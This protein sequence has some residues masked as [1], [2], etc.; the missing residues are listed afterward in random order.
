MWVRCFII[1][2]NARQT[3]KLQRTKLWIAQAVATKMYRFAPELSTLRGTG[4]VR[5]VCAGTS[6]CSAVVCRFGY[7]RITNI[8][9]MDVLFASV[10]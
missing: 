7:A 5:S 10:M 1:A 4:D 3:L 8:I 2:S 6:L 9:I